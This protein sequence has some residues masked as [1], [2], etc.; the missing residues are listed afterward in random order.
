M[1]TMCLI[2]EHLD[3]LR[4]SQ[5][6]YR[7]KV[8]TDSIICRIVYKHSLCIRIFLDSPRHLVNLHSKRNTKLRIRLRID[9]NRYRSAKHE[10]IKS[11]FMNISRKYNLVSCLAG[12]QNHGLHRRGS[13]S[14]HKKGICR[15]K[16]IRRK[17]LRL[18][19]YR[20]R[21]AQIVKRLH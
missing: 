19:D 2:R 11:T 14:Y 7:L 8:R 6:N 13:A 18:S 1:C 16:G 20:N 9:I 21:M 10:C 12:G 3:S 5:R 4:M 17:L 15:S